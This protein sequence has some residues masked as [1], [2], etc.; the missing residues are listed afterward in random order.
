MVGLGEGEA[1]V[2]QVMK[3]LKAAGCDFLT[4]GQY[5]QP[6]KDHY[7]VKE[8]VHPDLFKKYEEIGLEIGFKAV[9]SGPLIRSSYDAL[10]MFNKI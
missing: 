5:L 6:S 1:E 3:D 7:P 9:A 4:I 2:I 8:Y 10:E